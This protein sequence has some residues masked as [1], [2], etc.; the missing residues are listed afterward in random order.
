MKYGIQNLSMAFFGSTPDLAVS[1]PNVGSNLGLV[2]QLSGTVGAACAA[3]NLGIPAIAFSGTSGDPS[4][5]TSETQ[6]H[7]IVYAGLSTTIATAL[8]DSGAPYLPGNTFLNVNYPEVTDKACPRV[9]D[10][11]FVLSR[12]NYPLFADDDVQ[13][14]GSTRLPTESDVVGTT[15]CFASISV[16]DSNSKLDAN[17]TS[18]AVVLGK[19]EHML[20]CLSYVSSWH[21]LRGFTLAL[22]LLTSLAGRAAQHQLSPILRQPPRQLPRLLLHPQQL[23]LLRLLL[24]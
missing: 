19:L 9:S 18:Q 4:P 13:H 21:S 22:Y 14:C 11:T 6:P 7:Q 8:L 12:M 20:S 15:G 5:W 17:A 2:A 24:Q 16:G 1:G 10:F 23:H 3:A